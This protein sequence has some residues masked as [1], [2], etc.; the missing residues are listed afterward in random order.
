MLELVSLSKTFGGVKAVAELSFAVEP[1]ELVGLI[2]PNGSGK[3]TTINLI[4]GLMRPTSGAIRFLGEPIAALRPHRIVALGLARSFQNLRLFAE[5]TAYDNVRAAQNVVC[6]S[7]AKLFNILPTRSERALR[8]E[9]LALL[10]RFDLFER[11]DEPAG[12]LAYGDQKRLELARALA[13][14]PSLLL[15]D[16]P[17]GGMNPVE[18]DRLGQALIE[19]SREGLT[20]VLVEHHM[21]LVMGVSD[22]IVVLNFGRKI[23]EGKA[24]DVS[25]DPAVIEA[26]LGAK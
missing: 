11:R 8:E 20:I 4:S 25:R 19:L 13:T 23:A 5:C 1:G 26:Y 7:T 22:R 9:A 14:R 17:A 16:E 10:Q 3:T 6:R 24:E 18:V 15:L 12:R 2:G 21:K